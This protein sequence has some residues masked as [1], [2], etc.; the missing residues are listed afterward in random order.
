MYIVPS[1]SFDR[2]PIVISYPSDSQALFL[3]LRDAA[4]L[5]PFPTTHPFEGRRSLIFAIFEDSRIVMSSNFLK[6]GDLSSIFGKLSDASR[7]GAMGYTAFTHMDQVRRRRVLA[8][9]AA[10]A[11]AGGALPRGTFDLA[12]LLFGDPTISAA[13]DGYVD[14][15]A[16]AEFEQD[17]EAVKNALA[18]VGGQLMKPRTSSF[19]S[20]SE[21]EIRLQLA[22]HEAPR[23]INRRVSEHMRY[24]RQRVLYLALN[25][26]LVEHYASEDAAP[27]SPLALTDW[28]AHEDAANG[29][30]AAIAEALAHAAGETGPRPATTKLLAQKPHKSRGR[31]RNALSANSSTSK[32]DASGKS[33]LAEAEIKPVEADEVCSPTSTSTVTFPTVS[34]AV[35]VAAEA[36]QPA[37][38]DNREQTADAE[39]RDDPVELVRQPAAPRRPIV[40]VQAPA[41]SAVKDILIRQ[42]IGERL[43]P[44]ER[45]DSQVQSGYRANPDRFARL[46]RSKHAEQFNYTIEN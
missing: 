7:E 44:D 27:G 21:K 30:V 5:A 35:D 16:V 14:Q 10:R 37:Q 11:E 20:A 41:D 26:L 17:I 9:V 45:R 15:A 38:K 33:E 2:E 8:S 25:R 22:S 28:I 36:S 24:L 29:Q 4:A 23:E 39:R 19:P 31:P 3:H 40:M 46:L 34:I 42:A 43:T 6:K 12:W 18:K 13:V 1:Y 32:Q